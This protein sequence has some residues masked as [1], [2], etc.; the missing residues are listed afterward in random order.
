MKSSPIVLGGKTS[1][2]VFQLPPLGVTATENGPILLGSR[3]NTAKITTS[4]PTISKL[5]AVRVNNITA[6]KK[7]GRWLVRRQ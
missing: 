2:Q 1:L 5:L 6:I 4:S 3:V 7:G